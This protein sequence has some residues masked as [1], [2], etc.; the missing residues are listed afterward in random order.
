VRF[1]A[2]VTL[3]GNSEEATFT[4]TL[5]GNVMRGTVQIVG[6]PNGT[7]VGTRPGADGRPGVGRPGGQRPPFPR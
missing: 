7:F 3:G 1:T 5:T 4:G 6:H 2:P